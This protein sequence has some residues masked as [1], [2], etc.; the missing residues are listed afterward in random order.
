VYSEYTCKTSDVTKLK[1]RPK[2]RSLSSCARSS[3]FVVWCS[4]VA[5][6]RAAISS[7]FFHWDSVWKTMNTDHH[8]WGTGG[9]FLQGLALSWFWGNLG[10]LCCSS[11]SGIFLWKCRSSRLW[12]GNTHAWGTGLDEWRISSP[13]LTSLNRVISAQNTNHFKVNFCTHICKANTT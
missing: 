8:S 10:F 6:M 7:W 11:L 2:S 5:V 3:L 13:L 1:V 4:L 9:S 12:Y